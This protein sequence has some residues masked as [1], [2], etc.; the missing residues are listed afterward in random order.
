MKESK[1]PLYEFSCQAC[2]S[3]TEL[4]MSISSSHPSVCEKCQGGPLVK[5]ISRSNF[6][7][8][9]NGWYETDFKRPQYAPVGGDDIPSESAAA[10]ACAPEKSTKTPSS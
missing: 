1:M 3:L 2:G 6:A 8:K 9:G 10:A 5:I 7:L 4:L